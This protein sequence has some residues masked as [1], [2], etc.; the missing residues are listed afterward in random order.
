MFSTVH[1]NDSASTVTRLEFRLVTDSARVLARQTAVIGPTTPEGE[2]VEL[3]VSD[4]VRRTAAA[5]HAGAA[6]TEEIYL[7]LRTEDGATAR[8]PTS[9]RAALGT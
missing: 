7:E 6:R 5:A 3:R 9:M 8:F 1:T 2:S 4:A